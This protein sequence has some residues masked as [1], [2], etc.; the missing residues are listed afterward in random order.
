[1]KILTRP[2]VEAPNIVDIVE[3]SLDTFKN[4]DWAGQ[5]GQMA[6]W[7]IGHYMHGIHDILNALRCAGVLT[8][9]KVEDPQEIGFANNDGWP[10]V[11]LGKQAWL[12]KFRFS[13]DPR[14]TSYNK[15]HNTEG[16]IA[17]LRFEFKVAR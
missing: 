16:Y 13:N 4:R 5:Y 9:F 10:V 8:D 14:A 17:E 11:E 1:M 6:P 3:K 12:V 7:G 2:K 15:E